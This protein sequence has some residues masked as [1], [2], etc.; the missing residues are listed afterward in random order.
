MELGTFLSAHSHACETG[1]KDFVEDN[2]ILLTVQ[3]W[4]LLI[5][6][7]YIAT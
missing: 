6:K 1:R 4:W 3:D 7:A 2:S 5:L